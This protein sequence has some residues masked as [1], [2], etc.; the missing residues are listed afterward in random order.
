[1]SEVAPSTPLAAPVAPSAPESARTDTEPPERPVA[2]SPAEVAAMTPADRILAAATYR[3]KHL[4]CTRWELARDE[5]EKAAAAL[6]SL[7]ADPRPSLRPEDVPN[8]DFLRSQPVRVFARFITEHRDQF[9]R[10]LREDALS[11][12]L[13]RR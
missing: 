4:A 7:P 10:L 5:R 6:A 12:R 11:G 2:P 8:L 1:M 13:I 3:E 9:N